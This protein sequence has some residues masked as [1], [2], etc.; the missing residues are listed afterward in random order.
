ML[1]EV[2]PADWALLVYTVFTHGVK[3]CMF[4]SGHAFL[5]DLFVLRSVERTQNLRDRKRDLNESTEQAIHEELFILLVLLNLGYAGLF[6]EVSPAHKRNP[7]GS[8]RFDQAVSL[9]EHSRRYDVIDRDTIRE[10]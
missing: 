6:L 7:P 9:E 2:S 1:L 3:V 10:N 4:L 8:D 5:D